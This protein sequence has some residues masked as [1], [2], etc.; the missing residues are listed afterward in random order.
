[1]II[2]KVNTVV[3]S[4][5]LMVT[6]QN[7][8][9]A[10]FAQLDGMSG[11]GKSALTASSIEGTAPEENP[12][13]A[14]KD[15]DDGPDGEEAVESEDEKGDREFS[16]S[17][18]LLRMAASPS[19]DACIQEKSRC[20]MSHGQGHGIELCMPGDKTK[21]ADLSP[22]KVEGNSVCVP[23][24]IVKANADLFKDATVGECAK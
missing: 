14:C 7:C 20:C 18:V 12:V 15:D 19:M 3:V 9:Q 4:L 24:E 16:L 2:E 10:K 21:L 17:R 6:F 23:A 22:I 5:I 1:M 11:T 8:Q 13:V